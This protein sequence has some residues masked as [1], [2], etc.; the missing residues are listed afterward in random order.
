MSDNAPPDRT[1]RPRP[2]P[3]LRPVVWIALGAFAARVAAA[4]VVDAAAR[5]RGTLCLFDDT[6][7]YWQLAGALQAGAPFVVWQYDV[8]HGALRTPGYPLFLAGCRLVFGDATLPARLAQAALGTLGV[9]VLMRLVARLDRDRGPRPDAATLAGFVA[10]F[11]PFGVGMSVLLLSEG[12]FVPLMLLGLLGLAALTDDRAGWPPRRIGV[13]LGT[14]VAH[15]AAILARPS[16][17]LFPGLAL[18]A[19]VAFAGRGRRARALGGSALVALGLAAAMAPWW[20]RNAQRYG[21]FVPTAV[22]LGAS[23]YDGLN[24]GATG[25]S[26][27][28]FLDDP[29]IRGLDEMTQ[30]RVLRERA[31]GWAAEHPARAAGLAVIKAARFW[32]PWPNAE[33]VASPWI[34][35]ASALVTLPLYA[36]MAVGVWD[37]RR[38]GRA[39]GLLLG[40]LLY[41]A[42]IHM[43][44][45]GSLRYR[46]P[47]TAPAL[48]LAGFGLDWIRERWLRGHG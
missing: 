47:A 48:G 21:R 22:W 10:A 26:D 25:A 19:W 1:A 6:A 43:V 29:A 35:M 18:L 8:P 16:W 31:L 11:E 13:A 41:F 4:L 27:M 45:V 42:A 46:I 20:V 7:I 3:G 15:G 24:P 34:R 9:L 32:S 37:R 40:P 17:A 38:D 44:F 36:V 5:R 23:L 12:L 33:E 39:L 14:G 28:R 30:D 2:R